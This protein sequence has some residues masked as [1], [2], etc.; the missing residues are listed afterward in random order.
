MSDTLLITLIGVMPSLTGI[1]LAI[2]TLFT[3]ASRAEVDSLR[4]TIEA[5]TQE[6]ERLRQRVTAQDKQIAELQAEKLVQGEEIAV[7]QNKLE[8]L[9]I[10]NGK[11]RK[12]KSTRS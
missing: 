9:S 8:E 5:L 3:K 12:V 11:L 2:I 4:K 7:L 6:N 1:V 10:E